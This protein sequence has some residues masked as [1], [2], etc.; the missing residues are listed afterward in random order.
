MLLEY[1]ISITE[2]TILGLLHMSQMMWFS[3]MGHHILPSNRLLVMRQQ[4]LL[5][6]GCLLKKVLMD[7]MEL[8]VLAQM[9]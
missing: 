7:L 9:V 4:I 1:L 5:T 6:G 2:E 3:T 8:M